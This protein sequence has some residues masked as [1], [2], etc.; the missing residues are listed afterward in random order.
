M[1]TICRAFVRCKVQEVSDTEI[2]AVGRRAYESVANISEDL[3]DVGPTGVRVD[4]SEGSLTVAEMILAVAGA[5]YVAITTYDS[6]WSGVDRI[7]Q[8]AK[9]VGSLL[10]RRI[11]GDPVV[12]NGVIV[13]SR[14]TAGHLDKLHRL[15][16]EV[17]VGRIP[18]DYAVQDVLRTLRA[19]GES[20]DDELISQVENAFGA[21]H[22][23][24]ERLDRLALQ[25]SE[26]FLS[27]RV[28]AAVP[29]RA[30]RSRRLTITRLPGSSQ[31]AFRFDRE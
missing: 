25:E 27:E 7:R 11:Q 19:A 22:K 16:R 30:I 13:S 28:Y 15:H 2:E 14:V 10:R 4:V 9:A 26:V 29:R 8:H 18:P 24:A 12:K 31:V 21:A 17:T 6:F 23:G 5:L 20:I 3:A 1:L